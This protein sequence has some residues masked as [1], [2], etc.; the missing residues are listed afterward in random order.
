MQ[1]TTKNGMG[2]M[3][4]WV[5][6]DKAMGK[7]S[8]AAALLAHLYAWRGSVI[9]LYGLTGD[10][11]GD[12]QKSIDYCTLIIDKKVGFYEIQRPETRLSS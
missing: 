3:P 7:D 5:D 10:A 4:S 12:Y 9:E 8:A 11:T 2:L 1:M 6:N